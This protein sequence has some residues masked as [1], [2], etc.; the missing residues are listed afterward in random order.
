M[1][2]R[3]VYRGKLHKINFRKDGLE[4]KRFYFRSYMIRKFPK[5]NGVNMQSIGR[6][7]YGKQEYKKCSISTK[8][9]NWR[10]KINL[11]TPPKYH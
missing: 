3:R 11:L 9:A 8:V 7:I 10:P 6:V 5:I 1:K 4:R 2:K